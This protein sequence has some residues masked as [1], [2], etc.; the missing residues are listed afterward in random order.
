MTAA[1]KSARMLE[2]FGRDGKG[3]SCQDCPHYERGDVGNKRVGKC[4]VYGASHS[5]ATDWGGRWP[6][7]GMIDRENS[8]SRPVV[9]WPRP[10]PE[11]QQLP[12]Q[13]T[14]EL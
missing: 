10:R 11:A 13:I 6:A 4:F 12:G 9:K 3:R 5:E 7:C 8:F 1:E 14:F 2:L